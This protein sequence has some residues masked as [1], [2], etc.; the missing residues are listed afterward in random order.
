[1]DED[2]DYLDDEDEGDGGDEDDGLSD[3]EKERYFARRWCEVASSS[4]DKARA[5]K[6]W[7]SIKEKEPPEE[8]PLTDEEME[9]LRKRYEEE[10]NTFPR[11]ST[12]EG[13]GLEKYFA[14]RWVEMAGTKE[15]RERAK[16]YWD[17]I[18]GAVYM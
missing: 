6:Y 5:R 2:E 7:E 8:E 3:V 16:A 12:V 18:K 11:R 1:M 13:W 14:K 15:E 9:K 4:K 10:M 17:R